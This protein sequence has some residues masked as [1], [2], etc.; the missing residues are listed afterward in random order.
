MPAG[1][2]FAQVWAPN[3][4]TPKQEMRFAD[5]KSLYDY[6]AAFK[7]HNVRDLLRV[8]LPSDAPEEERSALVS[9]G[10]QVL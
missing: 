3:G 2:R 4:H 8:H 5:G 1:I 6:A 9:L 10:A 7:Q